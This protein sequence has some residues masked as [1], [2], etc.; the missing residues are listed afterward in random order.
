[1]G[2][3]RSAFLHAFMVRSFDMPTLTN[4]RA[5]VTGASRG[6]GREIAKRLAAAGAEVIA[7]YHTRKAEADSLVQEIVAAGGRASAVQADVSR[8][9][10]VHVMMARALEG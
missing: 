1:Y 6:I 2:S 10:E 8:A 9:G 5:L 3:A 7:A 4:R